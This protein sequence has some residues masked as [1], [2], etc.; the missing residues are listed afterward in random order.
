MGTR[1]LTHPDAIEHIRDHKNETMRPMI[2]PRRR[3]H[4]PAL[5]GALAGVVCADHDLG[6]VLRVEGAH[7]SGTPVDPDIA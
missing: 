1:M 3:G 5:G 2:P 7:A 6:G 4:A